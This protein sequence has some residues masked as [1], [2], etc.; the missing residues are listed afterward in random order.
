MVRGVGKGDTG[1]NR[2]KGRVDGSLKGKGVK[3]AKG[4]LVNRI[5]VRV[6]GR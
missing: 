1:Q 2:A 5:L 6:R 4:G 3:G